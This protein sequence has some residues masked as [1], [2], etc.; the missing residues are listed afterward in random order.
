MSNYCV[1]PV[2]LKERGCVSVTLSVR[3]CPSA[4]DVCVGVCFV[5]TQALHFSLWVVMLKPLASSSPP[6]ISSWASATFTYP[7]QLKITSSLFFST[8]SP[9]LPPMRTA[10][11]LQSGENL[12]WIHAHT[13][14]WYSIVCVGPLIYSNAVV[15][16][17][18]DC[19]GVH[20]PLS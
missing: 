6:L 9:P 13:L 4:L 14:L 2:S 5:Q 8:P 7:P 17:C 20:T 10:I 11:V 18:A 15:N 12:R 3:Q 19:T 16:P 1:T